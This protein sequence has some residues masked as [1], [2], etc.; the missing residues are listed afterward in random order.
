MI[1]RSSPFD[2]IPLGLTIRGRPGHP[3]APCI[4]PAESSASMPPTM[5]STPDI[6][7]ACRARLALYAEVDPISKS[8]KYAR[9][10]LAAS[11][12]HVLRL[13]IA[14]ELGR[15]LQ[16]GSKLRMVIHLIPILGIPAVACVI[17]RQL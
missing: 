17:M 10:L 6:T 3:L 5:Q 13:I 4:R 11:A 15:A 1:R 14:N 2:Q 9:E 7:G 16:P 12:R 8:V